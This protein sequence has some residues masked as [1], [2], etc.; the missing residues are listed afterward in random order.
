MRDRTR[1]FTIPF[2]AVVLLGAA[3]G[4]AQLTK[5]Q[6]GC[7]GGVATG[8]AKLGKAQGNENLAC[9]EAA[10]A[11]TLT[12]TVRS[13]QMADTRGRLAKARARTLAHETRRCP[14]PPPPFA[15]TAGERTNEVAQRGEVVV[16]DDLFGLPA[17]SALALCATDP[18]RCRCQRQVHRRVEKITRAAAAAFVR[19][20]KRLLRTAS[21]AA[22]VAA[23]VSDSA[24]PGSL[25][26]ARGPG[27]RIAS[28]VTRLGSTIAAAC[29]ALGP[30]A[31]PFPGAC[32]ALSGTALRDCLEA[33][34]SCRVC[35]TIN[36]ANDLDADCD[37]F[38][39]GIANGSCSSRAPICTPGEPR[40][41]NDVA[42]VWD[43]GSDAVCAADGRR[44]D[45]TQ[46]RAAVDGQPT[47]HRIETV[48]PRQRDPWR[49][50][51]ARCN[52][53]GDFVFE[54]YMNETP[55]NTWEI[56]LEGGGQ[57]FLDS[58]DDCGTRELWKVAPYK[59]TTDP[60]EPYPP[61]GSLRSG[62]ANREYSIPGIVRNANVVYTNYCSSDLWTGTNVDETFEVTYRDPRTNT[63]VR[64]P[65]VFTGRHNVRA[66][67]DTL[68][69]RYGL[70]DGDPNLQ[71][72]FRGQSAG[73]V[74]SINNAWVLERYLPNA[75][76]SHRI[77][78]SSWQGF[79]PP[80]WNPTWYSDFQNPNDFWVAGIP[81]LTG[82]GANDLSTGV[83][84]S[85]LMPACVG[86]RPAA[87]ASECFHASRLYEYVAN[88]PTESPAGLGMPL[89]VFQ[90]RDDLVWTGLIGM[91][92][93]GDD[94]P[95]DQITVRRHYLDLIDEEMGLRP[96]PR[97]GRIAW[98]HAPNDLTKR[99]RIGS[100]SRRELTVH[101]PQDYFEDAPRRSDPLLPSA[102]LRA[103]TERFW[104][105]VGDPNWRAY[106]ETIAPHC[107]WFVDPLAPKATYRDP[108]STCYGSPSGAFAE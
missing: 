16:V 72:H 106:G 88:E 1:W 65:W 50:K 38:D 82:Q 97:A 34:A 42:G 104:S 53:E 25:A 87:L 105:H 81:G 27:G 69:E 99:W 33:R 9:L 24:T 98:L 51:H 2:A 93:L 66:M 68:V 23:C 12:G 10:G 77:M 41:C 19:C 57:C 94:S 89:M 60:Y 11:G 58:M 8:G 100:T 80:D 95:A 55:T 43:A 5:L 90:N 78:V 52:Y 44:W 54:V 96:G 36:G 21:S 18:A 22:Q 40:P 108:E 92:P 37:A 67:L 49:W 103:M 61:D 84:Q 32:A 62:N 47:T 59:A 4:R 91:E 30:A 39:D 64:K 48:Y 13:C 101:P 20:E 102:N 28:Q 6:Q 14:P 71:V 17:D 7:V 15:Y 26:A 3:P 35:Q 74:G 56:V 107:N 75:A 76:G 29:D 73:G 31:N 45:T 86:D 46:C 63:D 70:D 79:A 85:E 83:W